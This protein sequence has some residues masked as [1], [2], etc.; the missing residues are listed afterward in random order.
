MSFF[1]C[2]SI[3][4]DFWEWK[5][6]LKSEL[7][8]NTGVQTVECVPSHLEPVKSTATMLNHSMSQGTITIKSVSCKKD[9]HNSQVFPLPAEANPSCS[10][11]ITKSENSRQTSTAKAWRRS[12]MFFPETHS[13]IIT[14]KQRRESCSRTPNANGWPSGAGKIFTHCQQGGKHCLLVSATLFTDD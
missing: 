3:S 7:N 4:C 11:W 10:F 8:W 14:D 9:K 5:F 13:F 12:S 1:S 6:E 2:R